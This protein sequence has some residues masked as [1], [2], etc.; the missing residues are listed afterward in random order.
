LQRRDNSRGVGQIEPEVRVATRRDDVVSRA[1]LRRDR[2]PQRSARAHEQD[3]QSL[4]LR[5]RHA[6]L[7]RCSKLQR[8]AGLPP[9]R[10]SHPDAMERDVLFVMSGGTAHQGPDGGG[11]LAVVAGGRANCQKLSGPGAKKAAERTNFDK[12]IVG[13]KFTCD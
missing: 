7:H 1:Q 2:T 9:L 13:R 3:S 12:S 10:R 6:P 4:R 11:P 8:Q 5:H